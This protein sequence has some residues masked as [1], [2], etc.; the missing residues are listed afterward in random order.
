MD[1]GTT[2]SVRPGP[3]FYPSCRRMCER[4]GVPVRRFNRSSPRAVAGR[5]S[6]PSRRRRRKARTAE[7]DGAWRTPARP[8]GAPR[9]GREP[10]GDRGITPESEQ[11]VSA[12]T[13]LGNGEFPMDET[14]ARR[15]TAAT[16]TVL[17]RRSRPYP[18]LGEPSTGMWV[19]IDVRGHVIV[20]HHRTERRGRR[21]AST[22]S[23]V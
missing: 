14:D 11:P 12:P 15:T 8:T 19:S 20:R 23:F 10:V 4:S 7:A 16:A 21:S 9:P 17:G 13:R 6:E 5:P 3:S 2:R 22:F 18:T 1:G